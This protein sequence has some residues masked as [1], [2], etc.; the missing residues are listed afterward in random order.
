MTNPHSL[1]SSPVNGAT[2]THTHTHTKNRDGKAFSKYNRHTYTGTVDSFTH[3]KLVI[4]VLGGGLRLRITSCRRP[5]TQIDTLNTK[6]TSILI[7]GFLGALTS[8][9]VTRYNHVESARDRVGDY[10]H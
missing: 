5:L 8:M 9:F 2:H 10:R 3:H 6:Y 1:A 4:L 7:I